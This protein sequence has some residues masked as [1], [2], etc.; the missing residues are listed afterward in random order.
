MDVHKDKHVYP[1]AHPEFVPTRMHKKCVCPPVSQNYIPVISS[2][3]GVRTVSNPPE[4]DPV[5]RVP[6]GTRGGALR[7][8]L[9]DPVVSLR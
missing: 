9:I 6:P 1:P 3:R 8:A 5:L 2:Y 4:P 7:Q